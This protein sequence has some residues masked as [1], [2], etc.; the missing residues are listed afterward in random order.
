MECSWWDAGGGEWFHHHRLSPLSRKDGLGCPVVE[1]LRP[2][3]EQEADHRLQRL[4]DEGTSDEFGQ[5]EKLGEDQCFV[6]KPVDI[7][8]LG[9]CYQILLQLN[10]HNCHEKKMI[11]HQ[12]QNQRVSDARLQTHL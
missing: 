7:Y 4:R 2:V 12:K 10:G 6:W 1:S 8:L 3:L 11:S 9:L 5:R